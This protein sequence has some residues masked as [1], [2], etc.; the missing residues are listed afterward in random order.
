VTRQKPAQIL[1]PAGDQN[2]RPPLS[3]RTRRPWSENPTAVWVFGEDGWIR[4]RGTAPSVGLSCARTRSRRLSH[5]SSPQ[6]LSGLALRREAVGESGVG[7]N[8]GRRWGELMAATGE[9]SWPRTAFEAS[10]AVLMVRR[11]W[12]LSRLCVAVINRHSDR[13]ADLPL[14]MNRSMRRLYLIWPN[15]GSIVI[16]RWA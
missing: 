13:A 6:G 5:S 1:A 3:H 16:L 12:S 9:K 7:R 15:T 8:H 10:Q 11:L 14:R 4:H 2:V